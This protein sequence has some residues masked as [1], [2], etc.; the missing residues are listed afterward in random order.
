LLVRTSEQLER[1]IAAR[2]ASITLDYLELYGLRPAVDRV[3]EHG[4]TARVASPRILKPTEQ[5][6][7]RYLLKLECE[8]V[9]RSG[10]LLDALRPHAHPPLIGDFSLNVANVVTADLLLRQGLQRLTPTHD[11]NTAQAGSTHRSGFPAG[12]G[13]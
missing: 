1:A 11:L 7:V 12:A 2:P 10:G 6:L 5:K 4:I 8:I 3:R 9:V 13:G